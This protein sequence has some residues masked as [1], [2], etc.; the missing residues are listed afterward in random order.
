MEEEFKY[1]DIELE[2]VRILSQIRPIINRDGGDIKFIKF[3][4]GVVYIS[5]TGA[6]IGCSALDVTLKAG[7]ETILTEEVPG[8]LEV[9][10]VVEEA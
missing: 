1:S 4:D 7:I 10:N 6:C 5:L 9:V 2:I 8:V 3:E